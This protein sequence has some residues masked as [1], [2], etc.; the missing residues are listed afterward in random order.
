MTD[1][2]IVQSKFGIFIVGSDSYAKVSYCN[3]RDN[4]SGISMIQGLSGEFWNNTLFGNDR[5]W[6]IGSHCKEVI[7]LGN[8]PNE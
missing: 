1:C 3:I 5:N 8:T 6:H 2:E 7:R 4:D